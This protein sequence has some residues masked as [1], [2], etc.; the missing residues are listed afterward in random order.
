[1]DDEER[2]K[3]RQVALAIVRADP[4]KYEPAMG[5]AMGELGKIFNV[6]GLMMLFAAPRLLARK[7]DGVSKS[8]PRELAAQYLDAYLDIIERTKARGEGHYDPN[9]NVMR[10]EDWV[11]TARAQIETWSFSGPVPPPLMQTGRD[12]LIAVFGEDAEPEEGWDQWEGPEED[13]DEE[14]PPAPT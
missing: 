5:A 14:P 6:H 12:F 8:L 9:D 7:A 10:A 13:D 1:M 4:E 3:D 11:R 2:E